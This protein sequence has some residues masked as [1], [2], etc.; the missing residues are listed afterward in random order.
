MWNSVLILPKGWR[1]TVIPRR[2]ASS[3]A[4]A[5]ASTLL[6][7]YTMNG[8]KG[9]KPSLTQNTT[10]SSTSN[11]AIIESHSLANQSTPELSQRDPAISL[12]GCQRILIIGRTGSGKTTLARE[13]AAALEIPHVELD[14][15][16]FE[17]DFSTVPVS[18]LRERTIVAISGE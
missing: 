3:F 5:L 9:F 15:L 7:E 18:V 2:I 17:P 10:A 16:Y 1:D 12:T 8:E 13:L 4:T 14:S 11:D 6:K